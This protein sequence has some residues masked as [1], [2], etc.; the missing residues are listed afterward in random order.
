[1]V[2]YSYRETSN[3]GGMRI[4]LYEFT[5]AGLE[6]FYNS[7]ER[8]VSYN[9]KTYQPAAISSGSVKQSGDPSQDQFTVTMPSTLPPATLFQGT[10]PSMPVLFRMRA[11]H[12]GTA[13][14]PVMMVGEI[15]DHGQSAIGQMEFTVQYLTA[16]L[17][18][19]GLRLTWNRS[20]PHALYD[21]GC[22]VD[23]NAYA[24]PGLLTFVDGVDIQSDIFAT[25]P[26]G[27]FDG[28]YFEWAIGGGAMNA[29]TVEAHVGN[30]F[31]VFGF[32]DGLAPG[33]TVTAYPGCDRIIPTCLF[34][35]NNVANYGGFP[36]MPGKSPFDGT[37]V[38]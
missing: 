1:M 38:F 9:G 31:R 28:G 27:W 34:K 18:A 17:Q 19:T 10:G 3:H 20:C 35:Y 24:V 15:T 12:Y 16:S 36:A 7:S 4:R 13:D 37:P 2:G 29:R 21:I 32:T 25:K 23:K 14:A 26:D 33:M 22:T 8:V 5:L 11:M 6:Y 30:N